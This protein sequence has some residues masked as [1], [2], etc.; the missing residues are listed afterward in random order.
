MTNS[1]P[2]RL[3]GCRFGYSAGTRCYLFT[4]CDYG[5]LSED[6]HL[7]GVPHAVVTLDPGGKGPCF[8]VPITLIRSAPEHRYLTVWLFLWFIAGASIAAISG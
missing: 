1:I 2:F 6:E 8:T 4:G 7:T 5:A 3:T